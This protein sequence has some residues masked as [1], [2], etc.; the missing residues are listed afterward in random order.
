MIGVFGIA[1]LMFMDLPDDSACHSLRSHYDTSRVRIEKLMDDALTLAQIDVAA[2]GFALESLRLA[3]M[4]RSAMDLIAGQFPDC[5]ILADIAAVEEVMVSGEM[6]LLNRALADLLLAAT[7]CSAKGEA[8][9]LNAEI[10]FG[11]V[12]MAMVIGGK[13]LPPQAIETFFDVGGQRVLLKGGGDLGLGCALAACVIRLFHGNVSVRPGLDQGLVIE[14][15]LPT[16][17]HCQP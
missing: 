12:H 2:D 10:K 14:F 17:R 3:P 7:Q 9:T 6:V 8:I 16:I 4:F 1:D 15:S 13:S 11:R 5:P